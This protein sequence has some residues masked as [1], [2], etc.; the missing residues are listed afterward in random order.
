MLASYT[1]VSRSCVKRAQ[2]WIYQCAGTFAQKLSNISAGQAAIDAISILNRL[3]EPSIFSCSTIP[4]VVSRRRIVPPRRRLALA[5]RPKRKLRTKLC[6]GHPPL[7]VS[8][9]G[10][11][12]ARDTSVPMPRGRGAVAA[13][14]IGLAKLFGY[15]STKRPTLRA[16]RAYPSNSSM[17]PSHT[18][19]CPAS[20]GKEV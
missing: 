5:G 14:C 4:Q 1:D 16:A 7:S 19:L 3:D 8:A 6:N 17:K 12:W 18:E 9:S 10:N 15:F 13:F 11:G 20:T 2:C